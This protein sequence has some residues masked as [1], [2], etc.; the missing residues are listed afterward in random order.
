MVL[1]VIINSSVRFWETSFFN[2]IY[3]HFIPRSQ[4]RRLGYPST[5]TLTYTPT[6]RQPCFQNVPC[7][8]EQSRREY[9]LFYV[10][11]RQFQFREIFDDV[12]RCDG[13]LI[14][15]PIC[16][17]TIFFNR[18]FSISC[19]YVRPYVITELLN[20]LRIAVYKRYAQNK[21][22]FISMWSIA[23]QSATINAV[24]CLMV[25]ASKDRGLFDVLTHQG[26]IRY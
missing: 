1:V 9:V 2:E 22:F 15:F 23:K 3:F 12:T 26:T 16:L 10:G 18:F 20:I 21:K 4:K 24:T 5:C 19:L 25:T 17:N 13:D 8:V 14:I 6:D 7:E 11:Y